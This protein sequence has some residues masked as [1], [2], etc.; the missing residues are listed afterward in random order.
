MWWREEIRR[1]QR[2]V[3]ESTAEESRGEVQIPPPALEQRCWHSNSS[4]LWTYE[5]KVNSILDI[6]R[7]LKH[8]CSPEHTKTQK[9]TKADLLAPI[10]LCSKTV[11]YSSSFLLVS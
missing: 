4:I 5:H 10:R 7:T 11:Q 3:G 9:V 8:V 2:R 1:E 6:K